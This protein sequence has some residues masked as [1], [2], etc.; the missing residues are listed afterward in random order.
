M[1]TWQFY[2]NGVR[3]DGEAFAL[4][5]R[6][7]GNVA[8]E[9]P[10]LQGSPRDEHVRRPAGRTGSGECSVEAGG[11]ASDSRIARGHVTAIAYPHPA[12]VDPASAMAM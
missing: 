8:L 11:A 9:P 4:H 5:Q 12:S 6:A 2:V 3:P 10:H 1:P 7:F